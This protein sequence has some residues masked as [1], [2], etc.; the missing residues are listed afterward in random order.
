MSEQTTLGTG[1][2]EIDINKIKVNVRMRKVDQSKV[3]ELKESIQE[4]GLL[5]PITISKNNELIAGAHRL[6]AFKQLLKFKIP[7][8][9]L[10]SNNPLDIELAEIDENLIRSELNDIDRGDFLLRRKEIYEEKYKNTQASNSDNKNFFGNRYTGSLANDKMSEAKNES[11]IKDTKEKLNNLGKKVSERTIERSIQ[12]AKNLNSEQKEVLKEKELPKIELL[13][14]VRQKPEI[15]DKIIE[16]IKDLPKHEP[17]HKINI[18]SIAKEVRSE[19]KQ[20]RLNTPVTEIPNEKRKLYNLFVAD[21]RNLDQV[22][23]NSIDWIITD[24]PYPKEFLYVYEEL[25]K[26]AKRVLKE[27]G[28]CLVLSGQSWLPEVMQNLSKNL[29]YHWT[30]SYRL[31]NGSLQVQNR[32]ISTNL[33]KPLLWFVKGKYNGEWVKDEIISEKREKEY[34]QWGQSESG[35]LD[36]I[37]TFTK[38]GEKILDPFL[39]GGTTAIVCI[40][41]DRFF[42]GSD[43]E[44]KWIEKT[45]Q[46]IMKELQN[47]NE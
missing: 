33:W 9:Y 43:I 35:F 18:R 41:N 19:N 32:N 11:F 12:I 30:L 1:P 45:E 7:C 31:P 37:K 34:H 17:N 21:I 25:G 6:E 13:E 20:E 46:R 28:S 42:I 15:K 44:K 4:L 16:K 14:L 39:G 24:P 29:N 8:I 38:K 3:K 47:G 2:V 26:V 22:E 36:I 10:N 27:N 5:Q 23:D 40:K